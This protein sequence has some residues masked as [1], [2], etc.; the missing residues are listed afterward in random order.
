[1]SVDN[2]T[3]Q[4]QQPL[5]L[6]RGAGV[7]PDRAA[8]LQ[9]T[10]DGVQHGLCMFEADGRIVAFNKRYVELMALPAGDLMGMSLPDLFRIRKA[11]GRFDHDP[12]EIFQSEWYRHYRAMFSDRL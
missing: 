10:L 4:P 1:M 3:A 7:A 12:D 8:L 6:H 9:A 11:A 5:P 2:D